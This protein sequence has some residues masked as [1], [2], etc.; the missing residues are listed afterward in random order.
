MQKQWKASEGVRETYDTFA[1]VYD[2]FNS[3]YLYERWTGRLLGKAEE[4][5]ME[6]TR[7]LDVA[8]GTGLSF[9]SLL[10]RGWTVTGCDISPLMLDLAREKAGEQADLLVADMRDLPDLG[11]FDL[12]WAIN[13]PLNYLL[14]IEE[15]EATF[16]GMRRNLAPGGIVLFDIN[17]LVTYRNFFSK[18]IVVEGKGQKLVWRG[19]Q[20]PAEIA[21]GMFAEARFDSPG[22]SELTHVHRQR[23]FGEAEVLGALDAAGLRCISVFGELEGTLTPGVD[24]EFHTK[25][26]YLCRHR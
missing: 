20:T 2:D 18:E 6:G 22:D 23:H 15:M 12:I 9:V 25:A 8:C 16:R 3:G 5:G 11:E 17:T 19:Q 4:A 10:E 14:S 26:I 13:D 7:L 21:P 24:E 1:P